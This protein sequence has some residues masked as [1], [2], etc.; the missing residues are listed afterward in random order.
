M[1]LNDTNGFGGEYRVTREEND[2]FSGFVYPRAI[3][4]VAQVTPRVLHSL[5]IKYISL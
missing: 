4:D 3:W 5:L 2:L 1:L